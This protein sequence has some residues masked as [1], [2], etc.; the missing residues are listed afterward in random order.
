M[1]MGVWR[2]VC[3]AVGLVVVGPAVGMSLNQAVLLARQGDPALLAAGS[4]VAASYGRA[5]QARSALFPQLSVSVVTNSN[6]REYAT[7]DSLIPV[8]DDKYNNKNAQ[9]N[10]SFPL[11]RPANLYAVSQARSAIAQVS[12]QYA[13][14]EQDMLLR[15]TQAWFDLMGARDALLYAASETAA[16]KNQWE[17]LSYAVQV[18]LAS[19]P[20]MEEARYKHDQAQ[21]EEFVAEGALEVKLAALEQIIG[22]QPGF[23]PPAL[24]ERF[25]PVAMQ[26]AGLEQWL[27]Q[28]E[29]RSPLVLAAT[30]A[31]AAASAEISK[32]RLAHGPTVEVVGTLGGNG[33]GAGTFPGQNGYDI[34]QRAIGLQIAIPIFSGGSVVG[35]V[36][37]AV[38]L[39]DKARHDLELARR[40]VRLAAK[41]AW[42]GWR[43]GEARRTASQ[44][45][46]RFSTLSLQA[47]QAGQ[48]NEL[49]SVLE[50]LQARQQHLGALRDLQR[51]RYEIIT[52]RF[53]LLASAG[54][55]SVEE[56]V[57]MDAWLTED[58]GTI[59]QTAQQP[60]PAPGA[61]AHA[62]QGSK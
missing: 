36:N 34:K 10:L 43:A 11:W 61:G 27:V 41:Q 46:V 29:E 5:T 25:V 1:M 7:R 3:A 44:Q 42:F 15:L 39:R 30:D 31:L 28:A 48:G 40:N 49:K 18:G 12:H 32:Q 2:A 26:S 50:V 56:V 20:A 16:T 51:S 19:A 23:R 38:A 22:P 37:E 57:A 59:L 33:Q 35:K 47:V 14:A 17:Q 58:N 8:S 13:A 6:A 54:R 9:L 55:L 60:I 52:S 21:A 24:S 62:G 53:K 4:N 45:A